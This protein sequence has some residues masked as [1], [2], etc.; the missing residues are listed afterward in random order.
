MKPPVAK[1]VPH[2]MTIHGDTRVDPYFWLRD[3]KDPDTIAYLEAENR[4]TETRMK[5]TEPLREK[6]YAE[7]LGRIKQTDASVPLKRD[8]YFYYT[9]TEEEKQ[10]AIQC[11]KEG[12]LGASEQILLDGNVL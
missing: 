8:N 3:R 9:G 1:T 10:Y 6:L 11:R 5:Q 12:A 2:P 7:M 4:Y